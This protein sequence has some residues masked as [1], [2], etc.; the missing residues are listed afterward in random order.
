[1][2]VF[3]KTTC[4]FITAAAFVTAYGTETSVYPS[5]KGKRVQIINASNGQEIRNQ[6]NLKEE[7]Y[8]DRKWVEEGSL[9][10]GQGIKGSHSIRS[11]KSAKYKESKKNY[12]VVTARV[13]VK[14]ISA[15]KKSYNLAE[16]KYFVRDAKTGDTFK[17][18]V[19]PSRQE[20]FKNLSYGET[21]NY[22]IVFKVKKKDNLNDNYLYIDSDIEPSSRISWHLNN[23]TE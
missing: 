1:M 16:F 10:Y 2:K 11:I 17:G 9:V 12:G 21:I 15:D 19:V 20:E 6:K 14:N 4:I 8:K 23:L 5:D 22:D 13:Q 18:E 3:A 7:S